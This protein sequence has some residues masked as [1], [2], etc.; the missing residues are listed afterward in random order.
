MCTRYMQMCTSYHVVIE[1][2]VGSK[3]TLRKFTYARVMHATGQTHGLNRARSV[4]QIGHTSEEL[5]T[6]PRLN[7]WKWSRSFLCS[8]PPD[9]RSV[10]DIALHQSLRKSKRE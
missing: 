3:V 5:K 4:T 9:L 8:E 6:S 10:G 1:G 7:A 2:G